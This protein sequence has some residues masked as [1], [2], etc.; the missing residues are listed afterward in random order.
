[1]TSGAWC[2]GL[3]R[4]KHE[5]EDDRTDGEGDLPFHRYPFHRYR[6]KF[7]NPARSANDPGDGLKNS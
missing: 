7:P 5:A 4:R 6:G 3:R 1:M 2:S